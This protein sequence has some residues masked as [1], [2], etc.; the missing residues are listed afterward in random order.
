MLHFFGWER[1]EKTP[2]R[3]WL[4]G[5]I[6]D[7]PPS[8]SADAASASRRRGTRRPPPVPPRDLAQLRP[9][10]APGAGQGRG[11]AREPDGTEG[12]AQA[13]GAL[14]SDVPPYVASDLLFGPLF[15]RMFVQH[16]P[17]TEA[18]VKQALQ[19]VLEGLKPKRA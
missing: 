3:K 4:Q 15:F 17:V 13:S 11:E 18:F 7:Q 14:R 8:P 1:N 2:Q 10:T 16:E 6:F 9:M 12:S 5:L 19:Y